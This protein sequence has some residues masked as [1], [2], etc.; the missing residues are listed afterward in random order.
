MMIILVIA[1]NHDSNILNKESI[2]IG[3]VPTGLSAAAMPGQEN[4]DVSSRVAE[5]FLAFLCTAVVSGLSHIPTLLSPA[6][7]AAMN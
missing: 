4:H 5:F 1:D 7:S 3:L 2:Q 6:M